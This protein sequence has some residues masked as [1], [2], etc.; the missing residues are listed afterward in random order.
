MKF[1]HYVGGGVQ[2]AR[3][4]GTIGGSYHVITLETE[5]GKHTT[6]KLLLDIG[7]QPSNAGASQMQNPFEHFD[8]G[9]LDLA[10][11]SHVHQDHIGNCIRLVK[12]GYRGPIYMSEISKTLARV[13]FEDALKHEKEEVEEYN[14]KIERLQEELKEARHVSR[15]HQHAPE[16]RH[17]K[18]PHEKLTGRYFSVEGLYEHKINDILRDFKITKTKYR[19]RL[20]ETLLDNSINEEE[21]LGIAHDIPTHADAHQQSE[22]FIDTALALKR[23]ILNSQENFHALQFDDADY[24]LRKHHIS[25][26]D[27]IYALRDQMAVMDFD[28]NDVLQALELINGLPLHEKTAVI[29]GVLDL[30]LYSAGHVE[31]AVQSV[32]TAHDGNDDKTFVYT[33][34]IG[35]FKQPS[36]TGKPDVVPETIDYMITEGTY[37]GRSHNDRL[38]E[39]AKIIHDISE[40]K[41][42]CLVPVFALQRLQD[43]LSVIVEAAHHGQLKLRDGEQIY[44]HTP[45]GY[46]LTKEFLLN[47][48]HG[49]YKNLTDGQL[50]KWITRPDELLTI[51]SKPGRKIIVCSG[52]MLERGTITQY[53]DK[54]YADPDSS[55][56]LTGFQVPGTNGYKLLHGEFDQPVYLNNKVVRSNE[57][58]IG[59]YPLS[60]HADHGEL[61]SY[62]S[63]LHYGEHAQ[64]T[65]VHGGPAR[66]ILAEDIKPHVAVKVNVPDENGMTFGM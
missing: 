5:Q 17:I 45:L 22:G 46:N 6:Y 12:A 28:E 60:G 44:C 30:T 40:T 34:D 63:S 38:W 23:E 42:I 33:G 32:W 29:P 49:V 61:A 2:E 1:T 3:P 52:G 27:D 58:H 26:L 56:V 43:V 64:V 55:F 66:H 41:N 11:V 19:R 9:S 13:I 54:V 25:S 62:L 14:N 16:T 35:R 39:I 31:G 53:I 7:N 4:E 50:I 57:A 15:I 48:K 20:K 18:N 10:F 47:D 51:L 59:Y 24:K 36:L 37:A 8:V 21:F 65:I